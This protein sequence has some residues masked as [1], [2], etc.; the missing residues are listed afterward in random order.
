MVSDETDLA[1][2]V[3]GKRETDISTKE[4]EAKLFNSET[5]RSCPVPML[6]RP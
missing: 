4:L 5:Y 2:V 1:V 6:L 3:S